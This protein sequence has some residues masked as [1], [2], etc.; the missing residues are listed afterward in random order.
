VDS[1][2]H[3]HARGDLRDDLSEHHAELTAALIRRYGT[4]KSAQTVMD[5]WL[6]DQQKM[7]NNMKQLM[8]NIKSEKQADYATVMV[9]VNS[10]SNLVSATR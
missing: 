4:K 2:W 5:Q 1:H 9:A 3:V 10:L 7:V 8:T 6:K